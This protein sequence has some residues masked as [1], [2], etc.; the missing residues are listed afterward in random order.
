MLSE[1][2]IISGGS[3]GGTGMDESGNILQSAD[4]AYQIAGNQVVLLS[5]KALPLGAAG[6]SAKPGPSVITI[7][8]AGSM[9]TFADDGKVDVRGAKGVRITAGPPLLIPLGTSPAV[10]DPSTD[11]VEIMVAE[12]QN[13]T[14]QCG[15]QT[16]PPSQS[17]FQKIEMTQDGITLQSGASPTSFSKIEMKPYSITFECGWG[18]GDPPGPKIEMIG[19]PYGW[20]NGSIKLALGQNGI[21]INDSGVTIQGTAIQLNPPV[22]T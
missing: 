17:F 19:G 1:T 16:P 8:A 20:C 5:R 10:A 18:A 6:P 4:S 22:P 14:L 12:R 3:G 2:E 7:L 21:T 15:V 13:I 11:G 9:P